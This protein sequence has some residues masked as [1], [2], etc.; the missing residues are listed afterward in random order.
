M[1]VIYNWAETTKLDLSVKMCISLTRRVKR[2]LFECEQ[3]YDINNCHGRKWKFSQDQTY[4]LVH[5]WDKYVL[6]M[7]NEKKITYSPFTF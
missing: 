6:S 2:V 4:C 3:R 7:G 1:K 5:L